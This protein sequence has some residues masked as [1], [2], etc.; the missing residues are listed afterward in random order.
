MKKILIIFL[1][2]TL[3]SLALFGCQKTEQVKDEERLPE[4]NEL[5]TT[6]EVM[7]GD[8]I[9]RLV[10]EKDHYGEGEDVKI[11]AELE[12]IGPENEME[13]RHGS[14]PFLFPMTETT[15][16]YEIE[17]GVTMAE[18]RTVLK[19]GEPLRQ[20]TRGGGSYSEHDPEEYKEFMKKVMKEDY[21]SGHYIVDGYASFDT[22]GDVE[23][24]Y[25]IEAQI[26]FIVDGEE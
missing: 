10:S 7:E 3:S 21:P 9:Y 19:K 4:P 8:F 13:I 15:R 11:Y 23:K 6:A 17:Y 2:L 20:E 25:L 1:L 24:E 16:N 22:A 18:E 5:K 12:Y 26:E 14:S